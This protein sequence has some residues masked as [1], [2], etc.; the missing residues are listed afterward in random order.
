[1]KNEP[2]SFNFLKQ[3]DRP[4]IQL[5]KDFITSDAMTSVPLSLIQYNN[6]IEEIEHLSALIRAN[7]H[8]PIIWSK[9]RGLMINHLSKAY[10]LFDG[11]NVS[12]LND[13]LEVIKFVIS[14]PQDRISFIFEDFHHYI[15][16][17]DAINPIVGEIR[18]LIKE[19]Y[20]NLTGRNESVYFFVPRSYELPAELQ[21]FFVQSTPKFSKI[22][23]GYLDRYGLLLTNTDFLIQAKPVIGMDASI[24]RL[25]QILSQ[26][27]TN[28]PLL[29]GPPGVGKTAAVEGLARMIHEK[30][31]PFSLQGK[32]LYSLSL[33]SLIAGT[34]YRGDMEERIEGLLEEVHHKKDKII[35]F[36]DEIHT[37]LEVGSTEGGMSPADILKPV[38]ARGEFP[39]IGATTPSGAVCFAKDP[40]LLRRF[41]KVMIHEPT[42]QQSLAILRGIVA[43]FENHHRLD[44]DDEALVTAVTMSNKHIVGEYLPGKAISLVDGAAAWCSM[45]GKN[46]VT[47]K[48]ILVEM[49]RWLMA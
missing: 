25:L 2:G 6:P 31:V 26:M 41:K 16:E 47:S 7:G 49:E 18:S 46:R 48:D 22:T 35:V 30:K 12:G 45:Q 24:E 39:C 42:T 15:G 34:R 27:E 1:M 5:N 38:L 17:K 11:F 32:A 20:R 28:N 10:P 19:L 37:L 23:D 8:I 44:I 13:P 21:P 29:V 40:A 9:A 36:I 14:K 4:R 3:T 33:N 43:C